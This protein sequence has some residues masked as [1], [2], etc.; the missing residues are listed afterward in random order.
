MNKNAFKEK[1][2]NS[3]GTIPFHTNVFGKVAGEGKGEGGFHLSSSAIILWLNIS[4]IDPAIKTIKVYDTYLGNN[5]KMLRR[6][7]SRVIV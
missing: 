6:R 5:I 3:G 2:K 7:R 1:I 4:V